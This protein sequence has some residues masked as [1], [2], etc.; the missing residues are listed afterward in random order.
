M[1]QYLITQSSFRF[2]T[3]KQ[4][5]MVKITYNA[6]LNTRSLIFVVPQEYAWYIIYILTNQ[7]SILWNPDNQTLSTIQTT[8]STKQADETKTFVKST[9]EQRFIIGYQLFYNI[10][11]KNHEIIIAYEYENNVI[12][13]PI[14]IRISDLGFIID[15][16]YNEPIIYWDPINQK[17]KTRKHNI[18]EI[19]ETRT[20]HESILSIQP[21]MRL[22]EN[23]AI[24]YDPKRNEQY[25]SLI[26]RES[27][28]KTL[29]EHIFYVKIEEL[30]YLGIILR[31]HD[32]VFWST[33]E[34]R[35]TTS[36]RNIQSTSLDV[37]P[38]LYCSNQKMEYIDQYY[39][40]YEPNKD[41]QFISFSYKYAENNQS[42]NFGIYVPL[43]FIDYLLLL[44]KR[45]KYGCWDIWNQS[46]VSFGVNSS[47]KNPDIQSS[48]IITDYSMR[49]NVESETQGI[50]I[51]I[52]ALN[53]IKLESMEIQVSNPYIYPIAYLMN[54]SKNL[55][56]DPNK[57]A[58]QTSDQFD[59]DLD[60][61]QIAS[62]PNKS[63]SKLKIADPFEIKPTT[64]KYPI[65]GYSL[66]YDNTIKE[67]LITL[68]FRKNDQIEKYTSNI[69]SQIIKYLVEHE[70]S[71]FFLSD[72]MAIIKS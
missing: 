35:L 68:Y 28:K 72:T 33:K 34:N 17:I 50:I 31:T 14:S 58:I 23:Y 69:D 60:F 12:T 65:I 29:E 54:I 18:G 8:T 59:S 4:E 53:S 40:T 41:Q 71:V 63:K 48:Y 51:R 10:N 30:R 61:T 15:L 22:I 13:L 21:H 24:E 6:E 19:L 7:Q 52:K 20:P 55:I 32:M 3:I 39:L 64:I 47:I 62:S 1:K 43:K 57:K 11:L 36:L 46:I 67:H 66:I 5:L 70:E 16:L 2:D 44:I 42:F 38:P 49:F 27:D 37:N 9:F 25:L 45:N 26:Y 56:W